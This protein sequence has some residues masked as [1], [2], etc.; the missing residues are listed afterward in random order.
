M[1]LVLR[2]WV[3]DSGNDIPEYVLS[4]FVLTAILVMLRALDIHGSDL[5]ADVGI[6]LPKPK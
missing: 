3:D 5:L 2:V 1:G 4:I 6:K